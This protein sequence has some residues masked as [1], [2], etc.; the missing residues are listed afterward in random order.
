MLNFDKPYKKLTLEFQI[1][2]RKYIA[3]SE[4][5]C[6]RQIR[7]NIVGEQYIRSED[8]SMKKI[9]AIQMIAVLFISMLPISKDVSAAAAVTPASSGVDITIDVSITAPPNASLSI[10]ATY[11][12]VTSPLTLNIGYK[13]FPTPNLAGLKDLQFSSPEGQSFSWSAQDSRTVGV[14]VT[15][16]AVIAT[17]AFV[18]PP[19]SGRSTKVFEIGGIVNGYEAF[20]LPSNQAVQRVRVKFTL[21]QPWTAVAS[22]PKEGDWFVIQ[23]YT[24][25]DI[26][27]EAKASGWSFGNVDFDQTKTYQDGVEIRVVGFKYFDYEHWNVYLGD[28]SLD[29]ALKTA[30][31]YHATYAQLKDMFGEFP[32]PKL[33]LV[34]PGYWQAGNNFMRQQLVGWS[35]YEYIP[36]HL[37][38][39]YFGSEGSRVEFTGRFYFLLREGYTTYSEGILTAEITGDPFWR[40]MMFER[41]FHY[42]RAQKYN[43][44]K[45]N[46]S[47]YVLGFIVAYLMDQEIRSETNGQKNINDLMVQIWKDYNQPNLS[48][49]SD[50]QVLQSLREITGQDWHMFYNQNVVNTNNLNVNALDDL[51]GDFSA[52]LQTVSEYWYNGHASMYFIQQEIVASSGDL[53]FNVR[54]QNPDLGAF[55]VAALETMNVTHSA[56]TETDIEKILQQV[57]GK[58]HSDFFEFYRSQGFVVDPQD[59]TEA[60]K[61]F[62]Y[63]N[64]GMDNAIQLTPNT[65]ALGTATSVIGQLVDSDFINS[66]ELL[67]QVQVFQNPTGLADMRNLITGKGV[68][69]QYSQEFS[70]GNYGSGANYIFSLPKISIGEKTYTFFTINLPEDAGVLLFFFFAKNAEPTT[71]SWMGGFIGTQ[72]V[73]FQ[74]GSTFYFKTQNFNVVDDTPPLLSITEPASSVTTAETSSYCIN[75]LVEPGASVLI[76]GEPAT[77]SSMTFE[78]TGCVNLLSGSNLIEVVASDQA[79]NTSTREITVAQSA[80]ITPTPPMTLPSTL[81]PAAMFI[82]LGIGILVIGVGLTLGYSFKHRL[83]L[84]PASVKSRAWTQWI[85]GAGGLL[86]VAAVVLIALRLFPVLPASPALTPPVG[87]PDTTVSPAS[88]TATVSGTTSLSTIAPVESSPQVPTEERIIGSS[89]TRPAD[90]MLMVYVPEGDFVVGSNNETL[91][92]KDFW[93]DQTE[94]TNGMYARCVQA[95][96]CLP[97]GD[98]SSFTRPSYYGNPQY[99]NYP[100]VYVD[101]PA[102]QTYCDWTGARLPSAA[103]WEKAALGTYGRTWPWGYTAPT[104]D[105]ANFRSSVGDTSAVGSYPAGASP[106]GALDMVGNV[107]EWV[108]DYI[109]QTDPGQVPIEGL[110]GMTASTDGR[111]LRGGSWCDDQNYIRADFR[112]W[113]A[114]TGGGYFLVGFRCAI[115]SD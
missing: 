80:L 101:W 29:E 58:D 19:N 13:N 97:P 37:I 18:L 61:T 31:F 75:G 70:G 20:L 26:A 39:T 42:L 9:I 79:G 50:E 82:L 28:T 114:P 104:T 48:L 53:D 90:N 17:Y 24:Y 78:F 66:K 69:Y 22:Y 91:H 65:F 83:P 95:G 100:V 4:I 7:W 68:T 41:K 62:T 3:T 67:L 60:V 84:I 35:R 99:A 106:Y 64:E 38:H 51:K 6:S 34:G 76:N 46:S 2:N 45:Q 108:K 63:Q 113:C 11:S 112:Y 110:N 52:F 103:E 14:N 10:K 36:H 1:F 72:K 96:I 111:F 21:P 86:L 47:Q 57:T 89:W 73:S 40:G 102:A 115:S 59:I 98:L 92:L 107:W 43:N 74:S 12:N 56:L 27:L 55:A 93:I 109:G 94:V 25:E 30:D 54:M 5:T 49:V 44:L 32:L 85:V 8:I 105:Q 15:G 87:L 23:P 81:P 33:L 77:I 71:N 88:P 16:D